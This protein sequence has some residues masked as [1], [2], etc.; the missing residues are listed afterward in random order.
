[1][2]RPLFFV[3]YMGGEKRVWCNSHTFLVLACT[4]NF[5]MLIG[6]NNYKQGANDD[7]TIMLQ[8]LHSCNFLRSTLHG[9]QVFSDDPF[10]YSRSR[11]RGFLKA[12]FKVTVYWK[13]EAISW[14][15]KN[16]F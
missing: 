9:I 6:N 15:A 16:Y 13:L 2:A 5:G 8:V 3:L 7:I 11:T 12:A 14:P 4:E 1:M 10:L